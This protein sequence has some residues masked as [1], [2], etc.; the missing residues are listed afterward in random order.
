MNKVIKYIATLG[1]STYL[2][3]TPLN[4]FSTSV[5]YH[6]RRTSLERKF[7]IDEDTCIR[8]QAI[9]GKPTFDI[10]WSDIKESRPERNQNKYKPNFMPPREPKK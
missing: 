5:P 1:L 2:A 10:P 4:S 3:L 8:V 9:E 6:S 7:I